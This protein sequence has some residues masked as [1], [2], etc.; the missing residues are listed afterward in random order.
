MVAVPAGSFKM[1]KGGEQSART[2]AFQI[3][4]TEVT[5]AAYAR[6]V[7]AGACK[8]AGTGRHC[9]AR[10][11]D[12]GKHPI[13][14]VSQEQA[15]A[16]CAWRG[17]RLPTDEEWEKAAR[18]TRGR[19]A[20]WAGDGDVCQRA[21]VVGRGCKRRGTLPV[22]SLP[23]G[24]SPY[25]AVD[26][27]GNVWEW[28]ETPGAKTANLRGGA[29]NKKQLDLSYRYRYKATRSSATTGFRCAKR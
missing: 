1:G 21:V 16:Y 3:D 5:V 15:K 14:C 7:A 2:G 11:S 26:M 24:A 25:G 13:N 27:L 9:N 22:G 29:Y 18:G 20:P 6:C 17:K 28:T 8:P 4:R 19:K 23:R 10:E 12:R